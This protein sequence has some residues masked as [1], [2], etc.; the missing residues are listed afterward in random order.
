MAPRRRNRV[1]RAEKSESTR[2]ALIE[3]AAAVVGEYGYTGASIARIA[4]KAN[5]AQGTIY[6]YY[7]S[8]DD[9]FAHLLPEVGTMMIEYISKHMQQDLDLYAKEKARIRGYL[10]FLRTY[11]SFYRVLQEAEIFAP[12]AHRK[13]IENMVSGYI[14][15]ISHDMVREGLALPNPVELEAIIYMLLGARNYLAMRFFQQESTSE[16][17]LD[18]TVETYMRMIKGGLFDSPEYQSNNG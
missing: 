13:H 1:S 17:E 5:V 8:R 10:E 16:H 7:E 3:A 14:K 2:L 6:N 4:M 9:L 15:A 12:T 11:P 18:R